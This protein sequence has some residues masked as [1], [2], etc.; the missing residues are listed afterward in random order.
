MVLCVLI[1]GDGAEHLRGGTYW[2]GT[3]SLKI[4]FGRSCHSHGILFSCTEGVRTLSPA[5]PESL[6]LPHHVASPLTHI[7]AMMPSGNVAQPGGQ[8]TASTTLSGP[9][10]SNCALNKLSYKVFSIRQ[11]WKMDYHMYQTQ[12]KL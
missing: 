7:P 9:A 10:V 11:Q 1:L 4:V 2:E 3:R 6:R 12:S 8:G 5:S